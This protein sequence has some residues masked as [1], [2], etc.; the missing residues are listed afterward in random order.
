MKV[1][2]RRGAKLRALAAVTTAVVAAALT[3]GL[4]AAPATASVGSPSLALQAAA[5]LPP[6]GPGDQ[7][8]FQL[9]VRNTGDQPLYNVAVT[10]PLIGRSAPTHGLLHPA[11][12]IDVRMSYTAT[13]RDFDTGTIVAVFTVWGTTS[14]GIVVSDDSSVALEARAQVPFDFAGGRYQVINKNSGK[15]LDVAPSGEIVQRTANINAAS[16]QWTFTR[17]VGP[18][19]QPSVNPVNV[20]NV[21]STQLL[22]IMASGLGNGANAVQWPDENVADQSWSIVDTHDGYV[23]IVNNNSGKVLGIPAGSRAENEKAVQWE[24]VGVDDQRWSLVKVG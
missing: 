14:D 10:S 1:S 16:Q 2:H 22:G 11:E 8:E 15:A 9:T 19:P 4:A 18:T 20:K 3:S 6:A 21:A 5:L 17:D 23:S 13:Q 12:S 7:V 24:S